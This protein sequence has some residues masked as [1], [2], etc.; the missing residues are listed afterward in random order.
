MSAHAAAEAPPA[1]LP[2]PGDSRLLAA[3]RAW[4]ESLAR[5]RRMSGNTVEAYERDLRQF[6]GHLAARGGTPTISAIVALKPRDIRAFMAARRADEVGGRSLMRALAGLRSFAKYLEREGHGTVAAL[7]AVR[8]PKVGAALAA[9]APGGGGAR[10]HRGLLPRR[11][12][13]R[14]L[15]P[16][17]GRGGARAPCTARACASPRRSG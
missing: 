1:P 6:L 8:S 7:G 14:A 13:P 16:D 11:R 9:T 4:S 12:G 2:M 17:A 3:A 5:E 10:A 15:D